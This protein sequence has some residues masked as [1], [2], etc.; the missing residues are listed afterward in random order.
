MSG[1]FFNRFWAGTAGNDTFTGF[2]QANPGFTLTSSMETDEFPGRD[3]IIA[4]QGDDFVSAPGGNN[5]IE[6][7][8]GNDT[9]FGQGNSDTINGGA[10][11]LD[12]LA[13]SSGADLFI[14]TAEPGTLDVADFLDG[15]EGLDTLRLIGGGRLVGTQMQ[16]IEVLEAS[17]GTITITAA[18]FALFDTLRFGTSQFQTDVLIAGVGGTYDFSPIALQTLMGP[19]LAVARFRG[20]AGDEEVIGTDRDDVLEGQGGNNDVRGGEG[21]D[22]ASGA[23]RVRGD[24]GDDTVQDFQGAISDDRLEGGEG[25][26]T[27]LSFHG[28][29]TLTGGA[30]DDYLQGSQNGADRLEGGGGNDTLIGGAGNAGIQ[31]SLIAGDGDDSLTAS[32]L[33]GSGGVFDG[34]IG[35]DRLD[36]GGATLAGA[37]YTGIEVLALSFRTVIGAAD[38]AAFGTLDLS[39]DALLDAAAAGSFD[40]RGKMMLGGGAFFQG[41]LFANDTILG[42][43]L[44]DTLRGQSGDDSI[45]G[46]VGNDVLAGGEGNDRL[47]GG[48]GFDVASFFG[49]QAAYT[50]TAIGGGAFI[51]SGTIEGADTLNGIEQLRFSDGTV[52]LGNGPAATAG[53]DSIAGSGFDDLVAGG[54]GDDTLAGGEGADTLVGGIGDDVLQG[55]GGADRLVGNGGADT[56][57]GGDGND[58]LFGILGANVLE[59]GAGFDRLSGGI[60]DDVLRGGADDDRVLG[61]MGADTLAGDGGFDLL[62]GQVGPD[63]FLFASPMEGRDRIGDF[64]AG[65]DVIALSSASFGLA[66]GALDPSRFEVNATGQTSVA[67]GGVLVYLEAAGRLFWD[68]DGFGGAARVELAVLSGGPSLT[69]ADFVVVA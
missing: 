49:T 23:G 58:Q 69:A 26:D 47:D 62:L 42:S 18:N 59:G 56:L 20:G 10:G 63:A 53:P 15:G 64:D 54:A 5:S 33:L 61:G 12:S 21:N 14:E 9:L 43:S 30:D 65:E 60:G 7:G 31:H 44:G 48:A 22:A 16:G 68:A 55:E 4:G 40:F 13:G 37:T 46:H 11:A 39:S 25:A 8:D 67:G 24:D 41:A 19:S 45:G 52:D 28:A 51:V 57:Q 35:N 34:G 1:V 2:D 36:A 3:T 32:G 27:I 6:G 50:V 38:L 17:S 66:P 29:D